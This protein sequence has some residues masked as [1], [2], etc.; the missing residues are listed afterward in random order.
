MSNQQNIRIIMRCSKRV[1]EKKG[2]CGKNSILGFELKYKG[3][4][5]ANRR[6]GYKLFFRLFKP[7]FF[8]FL[9]ILNV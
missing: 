4:E 3:I 6:R 5:T 2:V 9:I 7:I 1:A 8:F